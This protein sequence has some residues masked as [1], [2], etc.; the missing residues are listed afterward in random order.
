MTNPPLL[1]R[2]YDI[3]MTVNLR[4]FDRIVLTFLAALWIWKAAEYGGREVG[5]LERNLGWGFYVNIT[6]ASIATI[7]FL[8]FV[9]LRRIARLFVR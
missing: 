9:A 5:L 3:G 8:L 4:L 1:A 2:L 7:A 6:V